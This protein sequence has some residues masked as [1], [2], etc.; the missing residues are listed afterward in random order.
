MEVVGIQN[1]NMRELADIL[2]VISMFSN[3]IEH[4]QYVADRLLIGR[5]KKEQ[6]FIKNI[7]CTC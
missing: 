4:T 2:V 1:I 6:S 7:H 3:H 5:K